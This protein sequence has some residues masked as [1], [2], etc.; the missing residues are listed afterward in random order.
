MYISLDVLFMHERD[1]KG[2]EPRT[3]RV[4]SASRGIC[5]LIYTN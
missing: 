3:P 5:I 4:H 2:N 1:G